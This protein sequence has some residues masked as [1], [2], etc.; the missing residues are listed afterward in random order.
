MVK[1]IFFLPVSGSFSIF[2]SIPVGG[3]P[4]N[5]SSSTFVFV[6]RGAAVDVASWLGSKKPQETS[7]QI[8]SASLRAVDRIIL[9]NNR[10]LESF[11]KKISI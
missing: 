8:C 11:S 10:S 9:K 5:I 2:T 3:A 7:T 6:P 4:H 1:K